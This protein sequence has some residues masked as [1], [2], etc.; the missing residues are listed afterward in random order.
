M[1][2][3]QK[4]EWPAQPPARSSAGVAIALLL[5]VPLIISLSGIALARSSSTS[6]STST[7]DGPFVHDVN[8]SANDPRNLNSHWH[9]ALGVYDCDHWMGDSS[10]QGIWN[11][12]ASTSNGSIARVNEPGVY[13]G[14]HS[15]DDG[16]IHMEPATVDEAGANATLG[17]Y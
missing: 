16:I 4:P 8:L 15:H 17:K 12:P 13:A 14:L 1:N 5:A 11:W 2:I 6:T 10:G 9:A 7:S 3:E